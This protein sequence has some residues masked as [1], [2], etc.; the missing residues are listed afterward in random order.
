MRD[1]GVITALAIIDPDTNE[2]TEDLELVTR[3]LVVDASTVTSA[4]A[5]VTKALASSAAKGIKDVAAL[6][7][8]VERAVVRAVRGRSRREPVVIAVVVDA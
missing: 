6:E 2:L 8:I 7:E 5:E 4:N 1:S 3:G